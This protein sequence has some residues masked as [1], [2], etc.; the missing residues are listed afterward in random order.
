MKLKIEIIERIN[1]RNDVKRALI[2]ELG[3][4]R[5]SLWRFL[6][7]NT[8]N[9]P[10]TSYKVVQIISEGL[11]VNPEDVLTEDVLQKEAV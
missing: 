10:L 4:S 5:G 1:G 7:E 11:S 9:G 8:S 6:K 3:T 2:K